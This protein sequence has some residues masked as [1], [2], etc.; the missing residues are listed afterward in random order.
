M[1]VRRIIGVD[2]DNTLVSYDEAI[3]R[4]AVERGLIA[5]ATTR[6]KRTIRDA[7]RRLPGG[8]DAWQ[9]IQRLVYG[10]RIVEARL[11]EGVSE[12][13]AQCHAHQTKVF[14]VSHKTEFPNGQ[15]DGVNLRAAA[16]AWMARHDFFS[17]AGLGLATSDVYFEST[18]QEKIV[19]LAALGC[20][21][22][23]DDLEETFLEASFPD[24][25]EKILLDANGPAAARSDISTLATWKEITDH[26]F[27]PGY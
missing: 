6:S 20:A 2:F 24:G 19:R 22:F 14:I 3:Y 25:V 8:E 4:I 26:L 11:R 5:P 18:R 12:F 15:P 27:G 9:D 13:F 17:A 16:T 1:P 21:H 23:I 7:L 10:V